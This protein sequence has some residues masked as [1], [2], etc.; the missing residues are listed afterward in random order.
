MHGEGI[1]TPH[2]HHNGQQ[3][4]I[5]CAKHD[6]KI[7]YFPFLYFFVFSFFVFLL[8]GVDKGVVLAPI[9]SG[10]K[11]KSDL[12]NSLRS[13]ILLVKFFFF[14]CERL[15]LTEQKSFKAFG[16][17]NDLLIFFFKRRGLLRHWTLK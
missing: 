7:M 17:R 2:A 13:I 5:K 6:F 9:S 15:I 10:S 8:F 14:F 11:R 3:P 1:S 16:P 4:L 12:R